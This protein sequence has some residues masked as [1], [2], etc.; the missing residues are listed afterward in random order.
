MLC[1]GGHFALDSEQDRLLPSV[2]HFLTKPA[3]APE[4][5]RRTRMQV[6]AVLQR[7]RA[8]RSRWVH[9][10]FEHCG[11]ELDEQKAKM[12]SEIRALLRPE[13]RS[14]SALT[15][16]TSQIP[17]AAAG[18]VRYRVCRCRCQPLGLAFRESGVN[19]ELPR[20]GMRNEPR[21]EALA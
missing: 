18:E 13:Q 15:A 17:L 21:P 9:A 1:D 10:A 8:E 12:D 7:Y 2:E 14:R 11:G 20:S 19:P 6:Q 4:R 5:K 16:Y 3:E